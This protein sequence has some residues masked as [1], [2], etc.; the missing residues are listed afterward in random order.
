MTLDE[1][2]RLRAMLD[3]RMPGWVVALQRDGPALLD[4]AEEGLR[5]K[6]RLCVMCGRTFDA[7]KIAHQGQP[8]DC[9]S[10]DACTL[11]MTWEEAARH[12]SRKYHELRDS[13]APPSH[14]EVEAGASTEYGGGARN[15]AVSD[16]HTG[17]AASGT[18]A[19]AVGLEAPA[20]VC[21]AARAALEGAPHE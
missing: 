21:D 11:D 15:P 13:K 1:I 4:L 6:E 12:W 20:P 7:S 19:G 9:P 3:D 8:E 14:G 2:K 17:L 16:A 18:Q 5:A 10:P